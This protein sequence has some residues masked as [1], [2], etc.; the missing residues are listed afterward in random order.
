MKRETYKV[1]QKIFGSSEDLF[2]LDTKTIT[3][4]CIK[5]PEVTGN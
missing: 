1:L 2:A 4:V 3:D 5:V